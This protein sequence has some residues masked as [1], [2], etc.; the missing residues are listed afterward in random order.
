MPLH[1]DKKCEEERRGQREQVWEGGQE[2]ER[3]EFTKIK[4]IPFCK[5]R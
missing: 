3:D 4:M 5:Y 1:E 2:E